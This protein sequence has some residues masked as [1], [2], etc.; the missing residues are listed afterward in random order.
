MATTIRDE[1]K[2]DRVKAL[3]ADLVVNSRTEQLIDQIKAW[4]QGNGVDVV[5][6]GLGGP[7]LAQSIEAARPMGTIVVFGMAAG[8]NTT[9][10]VRNIFFPQKQLRGS[11][12]SDIEEL[13]WGLTLL[14]NG[15]VKP[16][17]DRTLPLDQ[18]VEAHRLVATNQV[19]G[20]LVLLPWVESGQTRGKEKEEGVKLV[21][22]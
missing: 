9:L 15:Q 10:D 7:V 13:E 12:V 14:R 8:A 4:T 6:D 22:R 16:V 20:N 21:R 2:R 3:G 1:T 11:M 18:V 17:L 19:T 5:I